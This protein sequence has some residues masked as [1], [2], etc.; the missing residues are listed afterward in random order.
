MSI[1]QQLSLTLVTQTPQINDHNVS[2]YDL[3]QDGA[4]HSKYNV[5]N[6]SDGESEGSDSG[7]DVG[8][9]EEPLSMMT[10]SVDLLL[11]EFAPIEPESHHKYVMAIVLPSPTRGGI[12]LY[13]AA[14]FFIQAT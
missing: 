11:D 3:L 6:D 2:K 10:E 13:R 12:T 8:A 4:Y 9:D 1:L 5:Y 7:S 14:Y